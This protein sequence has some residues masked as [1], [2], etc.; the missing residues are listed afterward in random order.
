MS[1]VKEE[2]MLF[3]SLNRISET[4]FLRYLH[5]LQKN[6]QASLISFYSFIRIFELKLENT[7]TRWEKIFKQL[8]I[9]SLVYSYICVRN[10]GFLYTGIFIKSLFKA[11]VAI[12]DGGIV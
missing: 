9:F 8:D 1:S 10:I 7:F 12:L 5:S 3:R 6:I 2:K 11:R 4:G